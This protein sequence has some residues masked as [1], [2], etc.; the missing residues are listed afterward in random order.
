MNQQKL[1]NKGIEE[2]SKSYAIFE[3]ILFIVTIA[4]GFLGMYPFKISGLPIVSILYVLFLIIMLGF[5]LRKHLCTRC[6][7]YGKWCHCGWGKLSAAMYK[8]DSGNYELGGKLALPTWGILMGLPIIGMILAVILGKTSL[9]EE[10]IYFV[11]FIILVT[12]N[13]IM[14]KKD[15][16]ACKMRS[17]CPGS[18]AK[19]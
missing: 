11:P 15:C 4:F 12:I 18:A 3:N 2:A 6:Y 8:K 9:S 13:G 14:H 1:S 16:T 17:I 5:T 7:Y 10:L 19:N